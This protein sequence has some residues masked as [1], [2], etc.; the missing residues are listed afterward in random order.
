MVARARC[1]SEVQENAASL[2]D[3][4][5]EIEHERDR[6]A[7]DADEVDVDTRVDHLY[8]ENLATMFVK[9]RKVS[10]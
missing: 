9:K 10:L 5:D 3:P 2:H 4:G 7:G 6:H 8:Y 1:A